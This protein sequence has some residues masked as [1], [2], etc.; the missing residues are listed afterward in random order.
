MCNAKQNEEY[1]QMMSAMIKGQKTIQT[2]NPRQLSIS[3][4]EITS[5]KLMLLKSTQH[6]SI[7]IEFNTDIDPQRLKVDA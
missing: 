1:F 3:K 4:P 6:Q 7:A 5:N 2:T